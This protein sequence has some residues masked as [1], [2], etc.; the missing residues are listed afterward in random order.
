MPRRSIDGR[1]IWANGAARPTST[2][3]ATGRFGQFIATMRNVTPTALNSANK[4]RGVQWTNGQCGFTY[5]YRIFNS[6]TRFSMSRAAA[7]RVR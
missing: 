7:R 2:W 5:I 6:S 3:F 1:R 4:C